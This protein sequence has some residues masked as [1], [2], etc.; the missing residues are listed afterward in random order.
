M[1]S[2]TDYPSSV[3][4]LHISPSL[5]SVNI[6]CKKKSAFCT[7]SGVSAAIALNGLFIPPQQV[8]FTPKQRRIIAAAAAAVAPCTPCLGAGQ[9]AEVQPSLFPRHYLGCTQAAQGQKFPNQTQ[10]NQKP[11][12]R[13]KKKIGRNVVA[14]EAADEVR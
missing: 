8:Y 2:L 12:R 9:E 13:K 5:I 3:F 11:D 1:Q 4:P 14:L 6:K 7:H 10:Q